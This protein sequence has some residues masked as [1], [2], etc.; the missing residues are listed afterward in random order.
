MSRV[1]PL[2]G[3]SDWSTAAASASV[4]VTAD[5][6]ALRALPEGPMGL[7]APDGTLGGL[8]L[9]SW[10][11][12]DDRGAAYRI[13][14]D[15]AVSH[16]DCLSKTFVRL[17]GELG[18][19]RGGRTELAVHRRGLA[20][21][22]KGSLNVFDVG[23]LARVGVLDGAT[24]GEATV[25]SVASRRAGLLALD[26]AGRL[27]RPAPTGWS[28]VPIQ[29]TASEWRRVLVDRTGAPFVLVVTDEGLG[30]VEL[31]EDG[32]RVADV[33]VRDPR[34]VAARFGPCP[35]RDASGRFRLHPL[36]DPVG[37][38][39]DPPREDHDP[40]T[41]VATYEVSGSWTSGPID[42]GIYRCRWHRI[43]LD[44]GELPAGTTVLA[45]TA[46]AEEPGTGPPA[47]F[48]PAVVIRGPLLLGDEKAL[49]VGDGLLA[50]EGRYVWVRLDLTSGG[51]ATPLVER[52]RLH[53]PRVSALEDLPAVFSA[54]AESRELLERMLAVFQTTWDGLDAAIDDLPRYLDPTTVP[55]G[56]TRDRAL[57][58][59]AAWL[60]VRIEGDWDADHLRR[61]LAAEGTIAKRRGTLAGLRQA[62]AVALAGLPGVPRETDPSLSGAPAERALDLP[63]VVEGFTQR[64]RL[65]LGSPRTAGL[66]RPAPLA[67]ESEEGRLRLGENRL[68]EARAMAGPGGA[69]A[70]LLARYAHR[71]SVSVPA[72]WVKS[73]A[74]EQMLRRAI[75]AERPAHVAYDLCLVEPRLR[76]GVQAAVGVD[77]LIGG[78]LRTVL[79]PRETPR[80]A[81]PA[82]RPPPSRT[83]RG[84]LGL[85]AVLVA[86]DEA[87]DGLAGAAAPRPHRAGIDAVLA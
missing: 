31:A 51:Q 36:S 24:I 18:F 42:S 35:E 16:L 57:A 29:V 15:G 39:D 79:T 71:F 43:E 46:S 21:V 54:D 22:E 30:L 60:D 74:A 52:L 34:E 59:L 68:G 87:A 83:A 70:E 41:A 12:V 56:R 8:V 53:Y 17:P 67:A 32:S 44:L 84:R 65:V 85:D 2:G 5:G 66:A 58:R 14:T 86:V 1:R 7:G 47:S 77:T 55:E 37:R 64:E 4:T 11:A 63:A 40:R 48:T 20:L 45:S 78:P 23:S 82:L 25:C 75:D 13:D 38:D 49:P 28:A 6:I 33:P 50:Q 27:W 19:D 76:V 81:D 69:E 61:V 9:P 73:E 3:S 72:A 62:V 80:D 10:L 26:T